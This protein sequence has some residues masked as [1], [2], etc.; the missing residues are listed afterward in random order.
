MKRHS[1]DLTSTMTTWMVT[2]EEG[3]TQRL[4]H[5]ARSG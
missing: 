1:P 2:A 5:I 4:P 3:S